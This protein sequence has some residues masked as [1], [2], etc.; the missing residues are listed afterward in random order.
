MTNHDGKNY[1]K[2]GCYG[3]LKTDGA[4]VKWRKVRNYK[5]GTAPDEATSQ[6]V[7]KN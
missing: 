3:T 7:I 2:Y 1:H 6:K 4:T 5:D